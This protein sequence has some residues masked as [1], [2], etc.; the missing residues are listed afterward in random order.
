[1]KNFMHEQVETMKRRLVLEQER[2]NLSRSK[3]DDIRQREIELAK[4]LDE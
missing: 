2:T 4:D 3:E 1:M